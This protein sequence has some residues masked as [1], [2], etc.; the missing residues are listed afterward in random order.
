MIFLLIS[1][2]FQGNIDGTRQNL[3]I[4]D[5][6]LTI[7]KT[8]FRNGISEVIKEQ[9]PQ[10]NKNN[11]K[12]VTYLKQTFPHL[13][14]YFDNNDIGY[15]SQTDILKKLKISSSEIRK[16]FLVPRS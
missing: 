3:T 13:C 10:I 5:N 9:F 12:R 2:S 16:K 4:S 6:E 14:G 11:E 8:I 15:S 7:I 1:E